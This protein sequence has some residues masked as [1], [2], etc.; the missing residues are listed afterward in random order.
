MILRKHVRAFVV[1]GFSWLVA[2]VCAVGGGMR[3]GGGGCCRVARWKIVI[4]S[5]SMFSLLSLS[6]GA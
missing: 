4:R 3:M 6:G 5:C 2:L 1:F